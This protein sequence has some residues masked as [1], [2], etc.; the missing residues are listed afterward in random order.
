MNVERLRRNR[1]E[2]RLRNSSSN[3]AGT[4]AATK[5]VGSARVGALIQSKLEMPSQPVPGRENDT[6]TPRPGAALIAI[7]IVAALAELAYAVMNVSAMPV[8][9]RDSMHYGAASVAGI[10]TAFLFCEG[11]TKGA[12]GVLGDRIGRKKLIIAGPLISVITA[13]LTILV[14][15]TQ[16]Y[17][18]V[19][20][21]VMDGLGAA[22]LWTS[23]LAMIADVVPDDR[24]S[25]AMSLFNVSYMVGIA[26]GPFI[27]GAANDLTGSVTRSLHIRNIDSNTAS[28]YVISF[29]FLLTAITALWRVP[30]VPPHPADHEAEAAF[31][32]KSLMDNLR[33]MPEVMIMAAVTFLGVGLIM[34]IIKLFA[35]D[36]FKV[37][38]MRFGALLLIPSLVIG[39]ASFPLGT[40]GDRIGR[41]KAVRLGIGLC[42][43][44]MWSLVFFKSEWALVIGGSLIGTGFVI[45]FPAWM[46]FISTTCDP[47][48]RGAVMGAFGTAQGIGAMIGAPLGGYLYQHA[49]IRFPFVSESAIDSFPFLKMHNGHVVT[50]SHYM[51]FVGCALLLF[52][53]WLI[54]TFALRDKVPGLS[55]DGCKNTLPASTNGTNKH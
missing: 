12:F 31:S 53:S 50:N 38:Q 26:L 39:A 13:L 47:R 29:L 51:P 33:R 25:Q 42:A 43:V 44:S 34:M 10:G 35:M 4:A 9:L 48:Q 30:N 20:L 32:V 36:E 52:V 41:V 7:A 6:T 18:F 14:H 28:F 15:P 19:L 17:F 49:H 22:A 37:T 55:P 3:C 45:A 16:W 8:Y 54:A 27:G 21:R 46:A 11:V 2:T 5:A 23:A 1:N 24:R 40:L